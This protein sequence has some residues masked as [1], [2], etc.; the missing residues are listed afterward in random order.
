MYHSKMWG[1]VSIALF[2]ILSLPFSQT[3]A[4]PKDTL[5]LSPR[6]ESLET[7]VAQ[8]TSSNKELGQRV[9]VLET[10]IANSVKITSDNLGA[11]PTP[12]SKATKATPTNTA[13]AKTD[14]FTST[15]GIR[16]SASELNFIMVGNASPNLPPPNNDKLQVIPLLNGKGYIFV[17]VRN[18]S[19]TQIKSA[20]IDAIARDNNGGLLAVGDSG[21]GFTP[22]VINPGEVAFG[23]V[24]FGLVDLSEDAT[25]EYTASSSATTPNDNVRL[26]IQEYKKFEDRV[27]GLVV[28]DDNG[29][30][31]RVNVSILCFDEGGIFLTAYE[32]LGNDLKLDPSKNSPF[33]VEI[34]S[35]CP[36]YLIYPTGYKR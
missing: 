16:L 23:V 7:T 24:N 6:V 19:D 33:Q 22:N 21:A 25:I 11:T 1:I 29:I 5:T 35:S 18:N 30:I 28:N 27:V 31:S 20:K 32:R 15:E 4:Q 8:F 36:T 34:Y 9:S 10:T 14:A 26:R 12:M 3:A 17:F 2:G 13:T